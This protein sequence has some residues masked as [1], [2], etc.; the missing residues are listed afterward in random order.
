MSKRRCSE[1]IT[2]ARVKENSLLVTCI[3]ILKVK[4]EDEKF[5]E[6]FVLYVD[7]DSCTIFVML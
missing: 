6:N 7:F 3:E 1:E 2:Q 5:W 4:Y